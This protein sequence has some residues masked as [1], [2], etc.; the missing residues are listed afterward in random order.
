[1][2]NLS[3]KTVATLHLQAYRGDTKDPGTVRAGVR[4]LPAMVP[5][6]EH[7]FDVNLTGGRPLGDGPWSPTPLDLNEIDSVLWAEWTATGQLLSDAAA[8]IPPTPV[9]A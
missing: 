8:I 7:S 9:S 6:E 4:D 3:S 1:M 2:R 5:G